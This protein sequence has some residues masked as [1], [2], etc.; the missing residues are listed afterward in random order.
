MGCG[1]GVVGVNLIR[2][3]L[4]ARPGSIAVF[5]PAEI[6]SYCFYPGVEKNRMVSNVIFRMGGAA[7]MY[8]NRPS[9]RSRSKYVLQH[10]ERVHK[11]ADNASYK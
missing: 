6:T 4:K 1:T 3:L 10:A 5:V 2:D 7:T 11:G 9:F 8:S